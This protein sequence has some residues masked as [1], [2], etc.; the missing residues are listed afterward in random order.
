V[1]L[2]V[3]DVSQLLQVPEDTLF[4]WIQDG[5]IPAYIIQ[6]R[7][8]FN[9]EEI[10]NWLLEN[11]DVAKLPERH[12]YNLLRALSKGDVFHDIQ[13]KSKEAIIK[14]A[15]CRIADRLNIDPEALYDLI[16]ERENLM[17]TAVGHGFAIPHTRDFFL[18]DHFDV[19]TCVFLQEPIS[20]GALDGIPV[21]TLFFLLSCD[22]KRH[23]GLLAKLAHLIA[24]N[25]MRAKLI[26]QPKKEE[27]LQEIQKW[28]AH[29]KPR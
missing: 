22:G 19:I 6:N 29:V 10:E 26:R 8:R 28:E 21:H 11:P 14:C 5:K 27:L 12:N 2:E 20:F 25:E 7:Y 18:P 4:Q 23:L 17:P 1:D 13:D 9:R 3:Q 24:N 15:T 16:N